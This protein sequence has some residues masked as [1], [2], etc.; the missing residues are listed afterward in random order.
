MHLVQGLVFAILTEKNCRFN[1]GQK[2][3]DYPLEPVP[4]MISSSS[5]VM[6]C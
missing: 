1:S 3:K 4:D 6:A 2:N 5:L